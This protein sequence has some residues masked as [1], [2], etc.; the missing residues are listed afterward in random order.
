MRFC[1]SLKFP[2]ASGFNFHKTVFVIRQIVFYNLTSLI[3]LVFWRG[4]HAYSI[5]L[6]SSTDRV[7][8]VSYLISPLMIKF[9]ITRKSLKLSCINFHHYSPNVFQQFILSSKNTAQ[10]FTVKST[11]K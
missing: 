11:E 2:L 10:V 4:L 1:F 9:Q 8:G 7:K 5:V 6:N 3:R